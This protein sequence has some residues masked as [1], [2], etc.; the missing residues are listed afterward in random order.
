M[1]E[2]EGHP[3][4]DPFQRDIVKAILADSSTV[5]LIACLLPWSNAA[6]L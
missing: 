1:T 6:G 5:A 4:A 3:W 2:G